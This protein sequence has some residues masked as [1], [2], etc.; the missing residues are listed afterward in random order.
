VV[1]GCRLKHSFAECL[2][3]FTSQT[4]P[5]VLYRPVQACTGI[6][7][8]LPHPL[9]GGLCGSQS[10]SGQFMEKKISC[11]FRNSKSGLSSPYIVIYIIVT[12]DLWISMIYL[13]KYGPGSSV[14]IATD[15]G[16]DC[17]GSNP[18]RDKIFRP[19]RP[20]LAPTQPPVKWVPGLSRGIKLAGTCC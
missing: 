8:P 19:S 10:R 3:F 4:H 20:A 6:S 14:G 7:L 9:N 1:P 2:E 16:M 5:Q 15:Y 13:Y 18:S 11:L 17:P 12:F